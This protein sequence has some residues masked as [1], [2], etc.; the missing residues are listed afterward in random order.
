M[1]NRSSKISAK[2]VAKSAPKPV[3]AAAAAML[4]GG[5]AET[6]IGGA[7]VAVLQ[8]VVGLVEFLELVLAVLVARIAVRVMLHG[9]LAERDL[10]LA[11]VQVRVTPRTS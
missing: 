1:P 2:E 8:D 7:L 11:S 6:V 4:E 9:E 10:E 5:M 3:A